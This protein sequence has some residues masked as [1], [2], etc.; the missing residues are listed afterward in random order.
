M[1]SR[2]L[3]LG[4]VAWVALLA[5]W[6]LRPLPESSP[7]TSTRTIANPSGDPRD[8]KTAAN[9]ATARPSTPLSAI[10]RRSE[11]ALDPFRLWSEKY[12]T[13]TDS[14][15]AGLLA[16]GRL[17]AQARHE[18]MALLIQRDPQA[19][20]ANVLPYRLRSELPA[21]IASV[22]EKPV[23][24]RG[25]YSVLGSSGEGNQDGA[26]P[27][28]RVTSLNGEYYD[29]YTYGERLNHITTRNVNIVGVGLSRDGQAGL[30]ALRDRSIEVLD[31]DEAAAI[32]ASQKSE[33]I[34]AV[35]GKASNSQNDE[36]AVTTGPDVHWFCRG[37]HM[38]EWVLQQNG[39]YAL[40]AA[41][42]SGS[43][44]GT[45]AVV[46]PTHAQGNKR[47]LVIRVRFPDQPANFEPATDADLQVA[48]QRVVNDWAA[49]SYGKLQAEYVFSPT[50][51]APKTEAAYAASG[52][53]EDL[54]STDILALAQSITVG[55]NHPY[56]SGQF[57]FTCQVFSSTL[58]GTTYCGLAEVGSTRS[59]IR[60]TQPRVF[61]HE[62]GHNFGLWHANRWEVTTESPIGPGANVEYGGRY[63]TMNSG[64]FY[65]AAPA[66]N[67]AER[68]NMGWLSATNIA[69][70]TLSTTVR[71]FD[72]ETTNLVAGRAYSLRVPK[73]NRQY[74]LEWRPRFDPDGAH[75]SGTDNGAIAMWHYNNI[76]FSSGNALGT[77]VLD[78]NPFSL[79]G[80][81][82][83]TTDSPLVV[84]RTLSDPDAGVYFTPLSKGGIFPND[85]IDIAVRFE[86]AGS[87]SPPVSTVAASAT[88]VGVNEAVILQASA[89][90]PDGDTLSYWW[91]FGNNTG[92]I[93]NQP[94][95][96][97]RWAAAG[98][99]YVRCV[100]S[101]GRGGVN[102]RTVAIRVGTPNTYVFA[103]RVAN[104]SGVPLAGALVD[105]GNGHQAYTD[106]EGRY[107]LGGQPAGR[108]TT[109]SATLNGFVLTPRFS[110]PFSVSTS[111]TGLDFTAVAQPV[112]ALTLEQWLGI[113]G[114]TVAD[115]TGNPRFP[116]QPDTTRILTDIAEADPG[117]GDNYGQRMRGWF[118]P[119]ASGAYIFYIASDDAS[120]LALSTDDQAA[121]LKTIA[122]VSAWTGYREWNRFSSQKS[123]P[124]TLI[125]GQRY[126]L[127]ALQKEATGGDSFSLGAD[128]PD[129]TQQRPL[130][131]SYFDPVLPTP[132]TP[133]ATVISVAASDPSATEDGDNGAFTVS[134]TGSTAAAIT[135][136]F[137]VSGTATAGSDYIPFGLS[138]SIPAG[139]ASTTIPVTPV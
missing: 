73:D 88:S 134:R 116:K 56:A 112:H 127:E 44:G 126:Y 11:T 55:T 22:I 43:S 66:Y 139:S 32:K 84:G 63:S 70:P 92:S 8:G 20:I 61:A 1:K 130:P 82:P 17:L 103:G 4:V 60:C 29:T 121:N 58:F 49:W 115:L 111:A 28:R 14:D 86:K 26:R 87:N 51:T 74:V 91:D 124:V 80:G 72:A 79:G 5:G 96:T 30:L 108:L 59:W 13:A 107:L 83:G 131:A 123:Q 71:I 117:V 38:E 36:Q 35:S 46:P 18:A 6:L 133:P 65:F 106:F 10:I 21:E 129:G 7:A 90:D 24:G 97:N 19:A 54:L 138:V 136:Y 78:M 85:Y 69:T 132:P 114:A 15:R 104:G 76:Q 137:Q 41:G 50:L 12:A 100:V 39:Q 31:K 2:R 52:F 16:E 45:S 118:S 62:W 102:T 94:V 25:D 98:D 42:G 23:R 47:L 135:V 89:T 77:E 68:W 105:D 34:C 99:Y 48:L 95:Q 122:S 128:F 93:D 33:S 120:Q 53:A 40:A 57:D 101:D 67:T 27:I 109:L 113:T 81:K 110:Q 119:P 75:E 3:L 64:F 9:G 37:G 125:A